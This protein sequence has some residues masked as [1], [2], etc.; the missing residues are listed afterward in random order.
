MVGGSERSAL[1]PP[2]PNSG[3]LSFKSFQSMA[4]CDPLQSR[5]VSFLSAMRKL[6]S[7]VDRTRVESLLA[8]GFLVSMAWVAALAFLLRTIPTPS[9]NAGSNPPAQQAHRLR[10]RLLNPSYRRHKK[11]TASLPEFPVTATPSTVESDQ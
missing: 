3:R 2:V 9:V 6:V 8:V 1:Y 4:N 10:G 5:G 7:F 11:G